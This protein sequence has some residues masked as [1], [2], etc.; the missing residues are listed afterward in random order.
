MKKFLKVT[1]SLKVVLTRV[2]VALGSFE[3]PFKFR[4]TKGDRMNQVTRSTKATKFR[5]F[6]PRPVH[7]VMVARERFELSSV[8]PEPTMFD[9]CTTGLLRS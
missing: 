3:L 7:G 8:G 1:E 4:Q 6:K 9:H 5:E 2:D